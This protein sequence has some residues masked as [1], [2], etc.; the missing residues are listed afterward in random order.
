MK[1]SRRDFLALLGTAGAAAALPSSLLAAPSKAEDFSFVF[2][3]D[4]HIQPELNA[5]LGTDM[6]MKHARTFKAD[7][8]INGG[9][10]AW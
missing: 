2:L 6:A 8:A 9:T 1:T 3:T 4:V 5:A 7:F 10:T